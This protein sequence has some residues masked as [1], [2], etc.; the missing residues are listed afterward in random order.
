M[1][2][3]SILL[4][5][6]MVWKLCCFYVWLLVLMVYCQHLWGA[7]SSEKLVS[8]YQ[9]TWCHISGDRYLHSHRCQNLKFYIIRVGLCTGLDKDMRGWSTYIKLEAMIRNLLTSLRA[10][11]ELQN[12]AIR[13][14][15]WQQ[16][17]TATKVRLFF[18]LCC[19]HNSWLN[20]FMELS[21]SW[22]AANC[23][24]SQEFSATFYRNWR[25]T[26]ALRWSPSWAR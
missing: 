8:V 20:N 24:A 23:A 19:C 14:R 11:T 25:F 9:T 1:C 26:R 15:H 21:P 16:L 10:V 13:E 5:L 22:E 3:L 7:S 17:M 6:L 18:F 2:S 12:P 4:D